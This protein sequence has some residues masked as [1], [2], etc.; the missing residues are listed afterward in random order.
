MRYNEIIFET[1]QLKI[2]DFV[3]DESV[4]VM[5]KAFLNYHSNDDIVK[6]FN[7]TIAPQIQKILN[8]IYKNYKGGFLSR[9]MGSEQ[10]PSII[11]K[12]DELIGGRLGMNS[13]KIDIFLPFMDIKNSTS[14]KEN[15]DYI[16]SFIADVIMHEVV[17]LIQI[18]EKKSYEMTKK[19]NSLEGA[20]YL[21]LPYEMEAYSHNIAYALIRVLKKVPEQMRDAM[22]NTIINN[23]QIISKYSHMYQLYLEKADHETLEKIK[24]M[25]REL[26]G[27]YFNN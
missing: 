19:N 10:T 9:L 21:K 4:L 20:A 22:M 23:D 15:L 16:I 24:E 26:V 25:V 2:Q 12:N 11:F 13:R 6:L 7:N 1:K 17:H 8:R 27:D 5:Q 18:L 3:F 14:N